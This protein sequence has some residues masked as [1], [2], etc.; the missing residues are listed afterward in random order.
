MEDATRQFESTDSIAYEDDGCSNTPLHDGGVIIKQG[1]LAWA[2]QHLSNLQLVKVAD[3]IHF[4][5]EDDPHGI[6]KAID[7]WAR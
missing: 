5:Q 4:V 1:E 3:S 7:A 2:K 6:G